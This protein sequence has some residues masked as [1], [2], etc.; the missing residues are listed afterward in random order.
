MNVRSSAYTYTAPIEA[1]PC[2]NDQAGIRR[3]ESDQVRVVLVGFENVP[4]YQ[5]SP[6]HRSGPALVPEDDQEGGEHYS[7]DGPIRN[8][9]ARSS[10]I[11]F[12]IAE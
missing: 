12:E 5:S 6:A 10:W 11:S 9:L 3:A 4:R 1:R 8:R 7:F 2:G